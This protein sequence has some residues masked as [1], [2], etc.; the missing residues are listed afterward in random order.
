MGAVKYMNNKEAVWKLL[1][2]LKGYEKSLLI[3]MGGLFVSSGLNLCI[4]LLS[5]QIMDV[6]FMGGNYGLLVKLVLLTSA[7]Y[8]VDSIINVMKE[9]KSGYFHSNTV[10]SLKAI[11]QTSNEI[12]GEL[13]Q[14]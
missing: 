9:K 12:E 8:I 7:I 13:F 14:Q 11:L 3:I 6:G 1:A 4:P 5:R 2:L 10:F